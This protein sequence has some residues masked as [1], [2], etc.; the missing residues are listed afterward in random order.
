MSSSA[1]TEGQW[2]TFRDETQMRGAVVPWFDM[3][4]E[5]ADGQVSLSFR[6]NGNFVADYRLSDDQAVA[7]AGQIV[8]SVQE[9]RPDEAD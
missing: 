3:K 9:L 5:A 1:A 6:Q 4:A 2:V 7:L 8:H